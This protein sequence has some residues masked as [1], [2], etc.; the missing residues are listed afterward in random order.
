M[1]VHVDMTGAQA[2]L[3]G[4]EKQARFAASQALNDGIVAAQRDLRGAFGRTFTLRRRDFV[5]REG[6][7]VLQFAKKD[8][9]AAIVGASDRA[10]F[11][12]KH[13]EGGD[14]P[15]QGQKIAIPVDARRGRTGLVTAAQRPRALLAAGAFIRGDRTGTS[16]LVKKFGRGKRAVLRTLYVLVTRAHIRPVLRDPLRDAARAGVDAARE[17]FPRRLVAALRSSR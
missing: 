14:R 7:K 10:A 13:V 5:E 6:A 15:K 9:L 12:P 3:R 4:L 17:S 8:R 11:L 2:K 1:S 16:V